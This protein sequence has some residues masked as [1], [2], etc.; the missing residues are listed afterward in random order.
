M[1][2]TVAA[3]MTREERLWELLATEREAH[4]LL[5]RAARVSA[6]AEERAFYERLARHEAEALRALRDEA[7]RLDAEEFVQKA[8]DC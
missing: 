8:L 1:G 4:A 7:E 2:H 5:E 3:G 6:D